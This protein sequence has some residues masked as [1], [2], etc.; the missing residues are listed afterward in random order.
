[1]HAGHVDTSTKDGTLIK[2]KN[3]SH[4]PKQV[5]SLYLICIIYISVCDTVNGV[6]DRWFILLYAKKH[7][8]EYW[9]TFAK[10]I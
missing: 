2:D 9:L 1:M 3:E 5:P 10:L 8:K 6:V 4:A 7:F